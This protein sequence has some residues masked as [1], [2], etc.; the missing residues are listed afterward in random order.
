MDCVN[1]SSVF[2]KGAVK[3]TLGDSV[4]FPI[5]IGTFTYSTPL[6]RGIQVAWDDLVFRDSLDSIAC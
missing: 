6:Q 5:C 3:N 4:L 2:G 1:C